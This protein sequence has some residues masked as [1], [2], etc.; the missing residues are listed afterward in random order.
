M[1]RLHIIIAIFI[2][3]A[4]FL[5]GLS[6]S[7]AA[8]SLDFGW[9]TPVILTQKPSPATTK[10][11]I[12]W[13]IQISNNTGYR[14]IPNLDIVAVTD[15]GK[16]YS[17]VPDMKIKTSNYS[18]MLTIS[19]LKNNI[20]PMVTRRAVAVFS[21]ID[22]KAN[23]IHFYIGGLKDTGIRKAKTTEDMQYLQITYKRAKKGWTWDSTNV[24]E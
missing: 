19:D 15:T 9:G 8:A 16:Q 6:V 21:N 5:M 14:L 10:T 23:V 20:F 3:I 11:Y 4:Y 13:P 22:P 12:A 18:E 7:S 2:S 17:P 1:K 24:L